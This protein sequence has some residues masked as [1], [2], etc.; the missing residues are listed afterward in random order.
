MPNEGGELPDTSDLLADTQSLASTLYYCHENFGLQPNREHTASFIDYTD[1]LEN[2]DLFLDELLAT[3]IRYVFSMEAEQGHLEHLLSEGRPPAQAYTR[4]YNRAKEKFRPVALRDRREDSDSNGQHPYLVTGRGQ[5]AE[6]LLFNLLQHF[7]SAAPLIRKMTVTTSTQH[8]RYGADAVH[9]RGDGSDL[10][11]FVGEAKVYTRQS[12]AFRVGFKECLHDGIYHAKNIRQELASYTHDEFLAPDLRPF[13]QSFLDGSLPNIRLNIV[14][15]LAYETN[16]SV[17]GSNRGECV[18]DMV[19]RVRSDAESITE[20]T[21]SA[22][23][24][25]LL[26]KTHYLLFPVNELSDLVVDFVR[27]M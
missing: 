18:E 4:L 17:E 3:V 9:L 2:R 5:F 25:P 11:L 1:V 24:T 13:A 26:R 23:D 19:A 14:C 7:F 6:L 8:E 20:K 22:V 10:D 12:G 21:F 15:M 16:V 27:R